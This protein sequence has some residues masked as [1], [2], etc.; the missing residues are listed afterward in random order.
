MSGWRVLVLAATMS[1]GAAPAF[2]DPHFQPPQSH[3]G[4]SHSVPEIDPAGLG[5]AATLLAGGAFLIGA[6]IKR[7]RKPEG[8]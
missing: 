1:L 2:A 3:R 4:G 8:T 5:S 7:R 6:R